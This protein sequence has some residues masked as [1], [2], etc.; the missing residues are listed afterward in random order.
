MIRVHVSALLAMLLAG[1]NPPPSQVPA[2]PNVG[3][4]AR[5]DVAAHHLS[6]ANGFHTVD[7]LVP[8]V[9]P[10]PRPA[11]LSLLGEADALLDAGFAVVTYR[12][13]WELLQ[14]LT[15]KGPATTTSGQ[16]QRTYGKWLLATSDPHRIG[17]G[18]FTLIVGNGGRVVPQVIDAISTLPDVDT[19]RL[20]IAG[21]STN[22]FAVL[23]ALM[24]DRRL[25]A[26]VAVAACGDYHRFLQASSLAMGGE[27]LELAPDYERWMEEWEPIRHPERLVHAAL[28]MMNGA[29]DHAVPA[30]CATETA[31]VFKRAYRK[32][33]ASR[34]FRFVLLEGAGHNLAVPARAEVPAWFRRWLSPAWPR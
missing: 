29:D 10:P 3:P 17:E 23:H 24:A 12:T 15:A 30:R 26:G 32:A 7:V 8:T 18:Y 21:T 31:R 4:P 16:P 20:G 25:G 19:R 5:D 27:P 34:R 33:G 9:F 6:I 1:C 13:H 22:G 2:P 11:I 14:G 28:L